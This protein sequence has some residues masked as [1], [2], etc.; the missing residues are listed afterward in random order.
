MKAH[1]RWIFFKNE[2]L[3]EF[4]RNDENNEN[5]PD[6]ET[7]IDKTDD[8][9][10]EVDN[11][12]KEIN[13]LEITNNQTR[14]LIANIRT[15]FIKEYNLLGKPAKKAWLLKQQELKRL[16]R[17][18]KV[19]Q[20]NLDH[21][22]QGLQEYE[23]KCL[24]EKIR[25]GKRKLDNCQKELVEATTN[26]EEEKRELCYR[27]TYERSDLEPYLHEL[28]DRINLKTGGLETKFK[29][30]E[31]FLKKFHDI[32]GEELESQPLIELKKYL[33]E[34]KTHNGGKDIDNN[35]YEIWVEEKTDNN[36]TFVWEPVE[37]EL[38]TVNEEGGIEKRKGV[39]LSLLKTNYLFNYYGEWYEV[40]DNQQI[41][42]NTAAVMAQRSIFYNGYRHLAKSQANMIIHHAPKTI[43]N[44][45]I[46]SCPSYEI[47]TTR[48]SFELEYELN[49]DT[50]RMGYEELRNS[51]TINDDFLNN[52]T[53]TGVPKK[54][55][56]ELG[57]IHEQ[58]A[59][60]FK[61]FFQGKKSVLYLLLNKKLNGSTWYPGYFSCPTNEEEAR[62][63][64]YEKLYFKTVGKYNE[65]KL[66]SDLTD[67]TKEKWL[68]EKGLLANP[69][70]HF[71]RTH[72]KATLF[73]R[74][75][76]IWK[77]NYWEL[78]NQMMITESAS[79]SGNCVTIEASG[80][81]LT[82]VHELVTAKVGYDTKGILSAL[83]TTATTVASAFVPAAGAVGAVASAAISAGVNAVGGMAQLAA[84]NLMSSPSYSENSQTMSFNEFRHKI[85]FGKSQPISLELEYNQELA[86]QYLN[87]R[88]LKGPMLYT[89]KNLEN[90]G[91]IL[92][93]QPT[94]PNGHFLKVSVVS[95]NMSK[96]S[97]WWREKIE[98]GVFIYHQNYLNFYR[99]SL[100]GNKIATVQGGVPRSSWNEFSSMKSC[101]VKGGF[102]NIADRGGGFYVYKQKGGKPN[103]IKPRGGSHDFLPDIMNEMKRKYPNF[104]DVDDSTMWR[105]KWPEPEFNNEHWDVPNS[106][107]NKKLEDGQM[108]CD[109]EFR[110]DFFS[111]GDESLPGERYDITHIL[112]SKTNT[113]TRSDLIFNF[114]GEIVRK[115]RGANPASI[116][117]SIQLPTNPNVANV[118]PS[119]PFSPNQFSRNKLT[120][121]PTSSGETEINVPEIDR[122]I[123]ID[124]P[125]LDIDPGQDIDPGSD[126]D[127]GP[128]IDPT[129]QGDND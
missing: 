8:W 64:S 29:Q 115:V 41:N 34:W 118:P 124:I 129:D 6:T 73:W 48:R 69:M 7:Y 22:N 101:G 49:F 94:D 33:D 86:N 5:W 121:N 107:K 81:I 85:L 89:Y 95:W 10:K 39:Y 128:D 11:Q 98:S 108:A 79:P 3:G 122:T 120:P 74:K 23:R 42:Y 27:L 19:N 35:P 78:H 52:T 59:A 91:D 104:Y 100:T 24:L 113:G 25:I 111:G 36:L 28:S 80:R 110:L 112:V 54:V 71:L 84:N 30:Y 31:L 18:L 119:T 87:K 14:Q 92:T 63:S 4:I 43:A 99:K 44:Q 109:M 58:L 93:K 51:Y 2:D 15:W 126:I 13:R 96:D 123:D 62:S 57:Y 75:I 53:L 77:G 117:P 55:N 114:V 97:D 40:M 50:Y 32:Q 88:E 82:R 61:E 60:G 68:E 66:T 67:Y 125:P 65:K 56:N 83:I 16:E 38:E 106:Y 20:Y 46:C 21:S 47:Y 103:Y 37:L 1:I 102:D 116:P 76:P 45:E 26:Y 90:V 17:E 127:W 9:W 70:H 72:I 12:Q 105:V